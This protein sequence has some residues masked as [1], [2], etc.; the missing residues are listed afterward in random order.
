MGT[1]DNTCCPIQSLD[2]AQGIYALL[3]EWTR[4]RNTCPRQLLPPGA[5]FANTERCTRRKFQ[6]FLWRLNKYDLDSIR[7]K[8]PH[9]PV[10]FN[11]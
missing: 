1:L 8:F 5:I 2:A 7:V 3:G 10:C 11:P 4:G 6:D 9:A